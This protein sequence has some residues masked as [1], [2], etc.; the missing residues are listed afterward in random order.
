MTDS[1]SYSSSSTSS[2]SSSNTPLMADPLHVSLGLFI[3]LILFVF[4]LLLP[5]GVRKQYFGAYPKRHAW[6]A[7]MRNYSGS[8][9]STA[10]SN[11]GAN[12]Q[13]RGNMMGAQATV[14]RRRRRRE[15]IISCDT[16]RE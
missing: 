10:N 16:V 8:I 4:Y 6:S 3:C 13:Q 14:R 11:V 9:A 5:R 12:K 2:S 15:M 7:R 1:Y